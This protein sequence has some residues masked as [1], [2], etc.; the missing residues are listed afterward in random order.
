M[1][2]ESATAEVRILGGPHLGAAVRLGPGQYVF[3]SDDD[4]DFVLSDPSVAPHQLVLTV[5]LTAEEVRVSARALSGQAFLEGAALPAADT[6][7][8]PGTVLALGFTAL[9]WRTAGDSWGPVTLVSRE[10]PVPP[11]AGTPET[12]P[13]AASEEEE[14][15]APETKEAAGPSDSQDDQDNADSPDWSAE[16][17]AEADPEPRPPD[18]ATRR[19]GLGFRVGLLLLVLL[20]AAMFYSRG[21][22]QDD[23]A[24]FLRALLA[25]NGFAGLT[26]EA[27]S[28][29]DSAV[30]GGALA[31]DL[32]LARLV[33]LVKGQPFRVY[34]KVA[35]ANDRLRAV[36]DTLNAHGFYPRVELT[37]AGLR[38]AAYMKD[39]LAEAKAFGY[40]DR[41][42]S[43]AVIRIRDIVHKDRLEP[44]IK[45]EI[46]LAG[47]PETPVTFADGHLEFPEPLSL[48]ARRSLNQAAEAAGH[49]LG[50]QI[51]YRFVSPEGQ[52]PILTGAPAP[53]PP[54]PPPTADASPL[55]GLTVTGVTLTPLKFVSADGGRKLFEGSVLKSGYTIKEIRNGEIVLSR[56]GREIIHKLGE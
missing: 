10:Y 4:C 5:D 56:D 41:D 11:P 38:V 47:L 13:A 23:R 25:D 17:P 45:E 19:R 26:V 24:G 43:E 7:V 53:P 2:P 28:G 22:G 27:E 42:V 3:G 32:E 33:E 51:F 49:R 15:E 20:L 54:E 34:L 36:R 18:P 12:A 30:I 1:N 44:V 40:V 50:I 48:E 35:V 8:P 39:G 29:S 14:P 31:D 55:A 37:A 46:R 16:T 21:S 6:A 9:A 52:S